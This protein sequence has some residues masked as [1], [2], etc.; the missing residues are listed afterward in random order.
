MSQIYQA[1]KRQFLD[2]NSYQHIVTDELGKGGQGIVYRTLDE[3]FALKLSLEQGEQLTKPNLIQH[4]IEQ[5]KAIQLLPLHHINI[6][7][8]LVVLQD[9]AGYVMSLVADMKPFARFIYQEQS[10]VDLNQIERPSWIDPQWPES[11]KNE[12][13]FF[14][15]SGGLKRRLMAL[16]R[17]AL[18]LNQL[19][20]RGLVYGDINPNNEFISE[21]DD[22]DEVW[23]I[24]ADN[25]RFDQTSNRKPIYFP[26]YGAPEL[27]IYQYANSINSDLYSFAI[28]AHMMLALRHPFKGK[29]FYEESGDDDWDSEDKNKF[30]AQQKLER[31]LLSWIYDPQDL[32]NL[33]QNPLATLITEDKN[34][35]PLFQ[36]CFGV[37]RKDTTQRPTMQHWATALIK[38]HDQLLTCPV[39]KFGFSP[40]EHQKCPDCIAEKPA[41]FQIE[42]Y[43]LNQEQQTK[44]LAWSTILEIKNKKNVLILQRVL[45]LNTCIQGTKPLFSVAMNDQRCVLQQEVDSYEVSYIEQKNDVLNLIKMNYR[46]EIST[47]RLNRELYFLVEPK[48]QRYSA[49]ILKILKS[50][51]V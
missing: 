29:A 36:Q 22:Y 32:S 5:I 31:G 15:R 3:G 11:V 46:F 12:V 25:I 39:C 9:Q 42:S 47:E 7:L 34:L 48:D 13:V 19:H 23:L 38:T 10:L 44:T 27:V 2:E 40:I 16:Y 8:P 41:Y 28:L 14:S 37:G 45:G 20:T 35:F 33:Q 18:I 50:G 43:F 1:E 21:S 17:C 49:C 24:D 26:D 6:A 4:K 51:I 30:T